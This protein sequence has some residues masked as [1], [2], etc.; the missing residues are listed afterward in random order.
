MGLGSFVSLLFL[1]PDFLF[2]CQMTCDSS[3]LSAVAGTVRTAHPF[4][5]VRCD[6]SL[7][8]SVSLVVP[9][10][11]QWTCVERL[12]WS[13]PIE[14]DLAPLRCSCCCPAARFEERWANVMSRPATTDAC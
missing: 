5:A 12:L 2:S 11:E 13:R 3:L 6:L 8:T 14:N 1:P 10:G 9:L 7:D 4:L